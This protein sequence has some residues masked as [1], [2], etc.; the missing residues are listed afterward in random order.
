MQAFRAEAVIQED[1][2]ITLQHLPFGPGER[3][4]VIVLA[5]PASGERATRYPLWHTPIVYSEPTAPVVD[6]DWES[7]R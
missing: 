4:E 2:T 7:A 1:G 5:R 6:D 3:V